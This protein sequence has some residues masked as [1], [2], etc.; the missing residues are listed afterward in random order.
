LAIA[1]F[2]AMNVMA[3]TMALWSEHIYGPDESPISPI[4]H[5][6]F[7]YLCLLFSLPVLLLLGGPLAAD[8]WAGLKRGAPTTDLLLLTGVIASFAVSM[9]SIWR[10]E[11]P[12]Y[13]EV[14]VVVLVLVT[15]GRWLEATGK[16]K[17][18]Q[19]LDELHKLIPDQAR[20]WDGATDTIIPISAITIGDRLRVLPGE[21]VPCDGR[22]IQHDAF[23]DEQLITGESTPNRKRSGDEVWGGSLVLDGELV[24][25]ATALARSGLIGQMIE[26]IRNATVQKGQYQLLADRLSAVFLPIV[27]FI[28]VA[29]VTYFGIKQGL[30]VGIMRGLAVVVIA[31]PCAMGVATPLAVWVAVGRL[32]RH[33][34]LVRSG[35]ALERL[36]AVQTVFFDKTGTLTHGLT[37]VTELRVAHESDRATIAQLAA[38]I[39]SGSLHP[40]AQAIHR[41]ARPEIAVAPSENNS[42]RTIPGRGLI[43]RDSAHREVYLG[44][45]FFLESVGCHW[46]QEL[47][48]APREIGPTVLI[49]WDHQVR[50]IFNLREQ[51]RADAGLAIAELRQQGKHV[52]LLSGDMPSSVQSVSQTLGIPGIGGL[53]PNDKV[54]IIRQHQRAGPVAM[55][56]DGLNDGPVLAAANVGIAMGSGVELARET[57]EVCLLTNELSA[58][59]K[60][61]EFSQRTVRVIRQNLFWALAYNILGIAAAWFGWL[62]PVLAAIAMLLSSVMVVANSMRLNHGTFVEAT[63]LARTAA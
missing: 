32:A 1:I 52:E 63:A 33:G 38:Q 28:C 19:A 54:N 42:V 37:E 43:M 4:F 47:A 7:R 24:I 23:V 2:F 8:A 49:G 34:T 29:A 3:F 11:G 13:F 27:A 59:P 39:T 41:W 35:A 56:G 45:L 10:D 26:S 48:S 14:G 40:H 44:S 61:F 55:I 46:P 22:I 60:L 30:D 20:Q 21:R 15:V 16:Q 51:V 25:E 9:R 6:L 31:C 58:L 36:A 57:A 18:T 17:A 53:L 62:N 5:N 12:I 50:G